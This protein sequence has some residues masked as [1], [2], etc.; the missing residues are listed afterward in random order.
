MGRP[1][2]VMFGTETGNAEGCA[3]ELVEA[4]EGLGL[5]AELT[6]MDDYDHDDLADEPYIFIVTSTFGNGDPPYNAHNFME[7]VKGPD[8]PAVP[9]LKFSVCGFGDRS[10][11]NFAQCG[12]DFD[13]RFAALGGERVVPRMDCDVDFEVP[14]DQWK[15]QVLVWLG[16]NVDGATAAPP[17]AAGGKKKAGLWGKVSGWFGGKK[18][19]PAAAPATTAPAAPAP[20]VPAAKAWTRDSPFQSK[21][22]VRRLLSGE[23]SAKETMHYELDL[24]GSDIDFQ[25]GDSFGVHPVNP[26]AEIEAI[27]V[28]LE[29]DP[30]TAVHLKG[31]RT[32]ALRGVLARY[33]DLQKVPMDLLR[34]ISAKGGPGADALEAGGDTLKAYLHDRFVVDVLREHPGARIDAQR[35]VD[36]LR[37]LPPRLYSVA[38]SPKL[39][40]GKVDFIVETLRYER[41]GRPCEGV[42]SVWLADR[43]ADEPVPLYLVPNP[44]FRLPDEGTDII[45]I[46]PGTGLAPFRAFL[47]ERE[48][49]GA[50]GRNWLFF[51]HQHEAT[52]WLYRDELEGFAARG[53][54][55]RVSY[56]WSRDQDHK[57]YVQDKM[58]ASAAELWAW[59]D[60][61]AHVFVC[62]DAQSMAGDVHQTLIQIAQ[63]QGGLDADA[64]QAYVQGLVDTK[65]YHR[66]VY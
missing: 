12:K 13:A 10:Y 33:K 61:G 39:D 37:G 30:E 63:E 11:P 28:A 31:G 24:A 32:L 46:G 26:P 49:D 64:A 20:A 65:R 56:A 58:K 53:I 2:R 1:I 57:V 7:F 38:N 15:Q 23:G 54:L 5:T 44:A 50:S 52:D 45:M 14:F 3:E 62:G 17:P 51:G 6:D 43:A 36:L 35:L 22:L 42:A 25:A 8:A 16:E 29:L 55:N 40:N 66:D 48:H 18:A 34:A 9:N 47:Q 21:I 41:Q 59:L 4:I 60:G 19:E 27:L